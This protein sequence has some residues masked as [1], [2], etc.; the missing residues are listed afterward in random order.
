MAEVLNVTGRKSLGK[1]N[2]RRLRRAGQLPAVI[3]GHGETPVSLTLSAE[4]TLRAIRH[5]GKLFELRGGVSESA[6]IRALQWDA[7]GNEVLHVDF[8]RVKADERLTV[9]VEVVTRGEAPGAKAGGVVSYVT[10]RIEIETI[11]SSIPDVLHVNINQLEVGGALLAKDI[12][13][14]PAGAV[15]KVPAETIIVQ[16]AIP[17]EIE[18]E[19]AEPGAAEP[20]VIGRKAEEEEEEE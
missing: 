19:A 15:L 4:E 7:L 20:E 11:A 16:C 18:E 2:S 5:G 1:R 10:H 17:A 9:E 12:E 14:M 3:Y 8:M 13:D 6:I